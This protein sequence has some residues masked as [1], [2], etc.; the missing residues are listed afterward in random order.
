MENNNFNNQNEL[1]TVGADTIEV[2][3]SKAHPILAGICDFLFLKTLVKVIFSF[4]E[5]VLHIILNDAIH[6]GISIVLFIL[7]ISIPIYYYKK[8]F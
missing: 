5:S 8:S 4:L 7:C 2:K 1:N 6:M 3:K